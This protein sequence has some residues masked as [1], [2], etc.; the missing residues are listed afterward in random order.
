[1][2]TEEKVR[3]VI[4]ERLQVAL[5]EVKDG[6]SLVDDLG[7]D[8]LDAVEIIMDLEEAF[9][10]K[11]SDADAEKVQTVDDAVS[12]VQSLTKSKEEV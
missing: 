7:A 4:A 3:E 5:E 2:E 1:M 9:G 8:S 11:I 10:I 6:S 12:L